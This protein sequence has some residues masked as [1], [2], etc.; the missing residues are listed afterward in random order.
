[1][2]VVRFL[3]DQLDVDPEAMGDYAARAPTRYDQLD[4]L[5][6]TFGF[7]SF[8]GPIQTQLSQWLVPIAMTTV[9][10]GAKVGHW[11][12]GDLRLRAE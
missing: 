9:R 7:R 2:E 1:M 12:G 11:S 8:C 6:Q 10:G 4:A 3:A 5:R